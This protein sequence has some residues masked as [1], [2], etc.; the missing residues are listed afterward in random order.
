MYPIKFIFIIKHSILV[1]HINYNSSKLDYNYN[2]SPYILTFRVTF[3]FPFKVKL[4]TQ[5]FHDSIQQLFYLTNRLF[6]RLLA[7]V[8]VN[9]WGWETIRYFLS[10]ETFE[11]FND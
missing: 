5:T 2:L 9:S 8:H 7:A 3:S 11:T 4:I 6:S 1:T 10:Q